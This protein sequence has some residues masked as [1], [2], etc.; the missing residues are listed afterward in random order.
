[1]IKYYQNI[2][3]ILFVLFGAGAATVFWTDITLLVFVM[4]AVVIIAIGYNLYWN[5]YIQKNSGS[6]Q[7]FKTI[8]DDRYLFKVRAVG[9]A[10]SF[11]A[12][13]LFFQQG[14]FGLGKYY[15]LIF[16]VLTLIYS[17]TLKPGGVILHRNNVLQCTGLSRDIPLSDIQGF[18]VEEEKITIQL[19]SHNIYLRECILS[20]GDIQR[21][22]AFLHSTRK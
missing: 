19:T 6:V 15:E 17:F 14:Q 8:H 12:L 9:I 20:E 4:F 10:A 21:L 2:R 1:M 22:I 7:T 3:Q 18:I 16:G 11:G 13:L 5:E